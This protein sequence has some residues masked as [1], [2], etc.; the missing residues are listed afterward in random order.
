MSP[1]ASTTADLPTLPTVSPTLPPTDDVGEVNQVA[2]ASSGDP[3]GVATDVVVGII[4]AAVLLLVLGIAIGRWQ[5]STQQPGQQHIPDLVWRSQSRGG[6]AKDGFRQQGGMMA[7][8]ENDN[9][10]RGTGIDN[11]GYIDIG[12]EGPAVGFDSPTS[13]QSTTSVDLELFA[14]ARSSSA[15]PHGGTDQDQDPGFNLWT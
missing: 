12:Q 15:D 2:G 14:L 8:V 11:A 5:R 4:V 6:G 3:A 1:T 9:V 10:G 13:R 7:T